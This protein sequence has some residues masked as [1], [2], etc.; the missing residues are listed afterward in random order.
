MYANSVFS[1]YIF[2]YLLCIKG[3][4]YLNIAKEQHPL[5]SLAGKAIPE[6]YLFTHKF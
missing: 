2:Q 6:I 1:R 4:G 5:I 3:W